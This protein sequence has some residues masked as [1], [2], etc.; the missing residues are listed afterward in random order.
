MI[1]TTREHTQE[2]KM[3]RKNTTTVYR[4]H[5]SLDRDGQCLDMDQAEVLGESWGHTYDTLGEA[6]E[7]AEE[8]A[9]RARLS[10]VGPMALY[11]FLPED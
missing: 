3:T 5:A 10:L 7:L 2:A 11:D 1:M 6:E 4:I 8:M 9:G